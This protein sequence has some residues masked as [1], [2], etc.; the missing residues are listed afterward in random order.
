MSLTDSLSILAYKPLNRWDYSSIRPGP[1]GSLGDTMGQVRFKHS[2]PNQG[3][4][5]DPE[6]KNN[7]QNRLGSNVSDGNH[8]SFTTG[9]KGDPF[10]LNSPWTDTRIRKVSWGTIHQDVRASDKLHEPRVGSIPQL[11]WNNKLAT[12]YNAKRTGNMF[13][14]LPGPYIASPGEIPRGGQVPRSEQITGGENFVG[15]TTPDAPYSTSDATQT[16]DVN[17]YY[18][19]YR[20]QQ[21]VPMLPDINRTRMR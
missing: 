14:P 3:I 7:K 2:F 13:L 9:G 16:P 12:V 10:I 17:A 21:S 6:Y 4:R 18:N 15:Y 5:L 8:T 20:Q 11:S 1:V 19:Q